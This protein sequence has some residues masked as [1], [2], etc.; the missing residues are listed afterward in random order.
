MSVSKFLAP[1]LAALVV[2]ASS[3]GAALAAGQ[4]GGG[5]FGGGSGA[6]APRFDPDEEYRKG[7]E[8][9]KA[10]N[11][12]VASR[13]LQ[14]VVNARPKDVDAYLLLGQA[15]AGG[16]DFK[17]ALRAYERAAKLDPDNLAAQQGVGVNAAKAGQ[18]PKAQAALDAVKAKAAACAGT[19]MN[20]QALKDAQWAIEA[21]MNPGGAMS[22]GM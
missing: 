19:C 16:G 2:M 9:L 15:K 4:M 18:A 1:A 12:K 13:A 20:A 8:A 3:A 10:G 21:A 7:V 5:D 6:P 11:F 22:S 17:G 14:N